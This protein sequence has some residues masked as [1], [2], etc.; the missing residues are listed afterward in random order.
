MRSRAFSILLFLSIA[1]AAHAQYRI[2]GVVSSDDSTSVV[3]ECVIYL[4]D[5]TKSAV[6]DNRG[7]FV[8]D[9]LANGTYTLHFTS[10]KYKY[11]SATIT[12]S[13]KDAFVTT[14]LQSRTEQLG[15]VTITDSSANFGF[16][17]MRAVES[18]GIYEG[19]K[20][21]VILPDQ[22]TVNLST[23]N[24]RQVYSRVAGLNIW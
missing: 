24:A 9:D 18:M 22:L 16:T 12:L 20:S 15:E 21:E 17:R 6:T 13:G 1:I 10:P 11:V 7:R 14:Y 8:F 23:N 2:A 19:K 4:N 3:K 5:G